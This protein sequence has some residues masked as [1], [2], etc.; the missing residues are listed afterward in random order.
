MRALG[1]GPVAPY[2]FL[3][4]RAAARADRLA[5]A[6]RG[7][8]ARAYPRRLGLGGRPRRR[9]SF[10]SV[11]V[12]VVEDP[13][14]YHFSPSAG[15][16]PLVSGAAHGGLGGAGELLVGEGERDEGFD[17]GSVDESQPAPPA[18]PP[19]RLQGALDL[20]EVECTDRR[21]GALAV[22][23]VLALCGGIAA[24]IVGRAAGL[25][26]AFAVFAGAAG[27]GACHWFH[28][29]LGDGVFGRT[30]GKLLAGVVVV[31]ALTGARVGFMRGL[32]RRAL[33]DAYFAA[34][35]VLGYVV[36]GVRNHGVFWPAGVFEPAADL[37]VAG[38]AAGALLIP[39]FV[40]RSVAFGGQWLHD[41]L[42]G[43]CV[44]VP[45]PMPTSR[46]SHGRRR[47]FEFRDPPPRVVPPP[48][49][50]PTLRSPD[51]DQDVYRVALA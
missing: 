6:L 27:A 39:F 16:A 43:S 48:A 40:Y 32:S 38:L 18:G 31:D 22:D 10:P 21:L 44:V 41:R 29:A 5:D 35:A 34:A 14:V 1:F 36:A 2:G 17:D 47:L 25:D 13:P 24:A 37:W 8:A 23:L 26:A 11:V 46:L 20:G 42:A 49:S 28:A 12:G 51:D 15:S 33:C 7:A 9:S 4:H 50:L 45:T 3:Q 30:I 19:P